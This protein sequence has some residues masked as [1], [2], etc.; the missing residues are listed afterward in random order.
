MGWGLT[1]HGECNFIYS[2]GRTSMEGSL[3]ARDGDKQEVFVCVPC[4]CSMH[5]WSYYQSMGFLG[6]DWSYMSI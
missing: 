2:Q 3:T 5:R 4:T 6:C 1:F